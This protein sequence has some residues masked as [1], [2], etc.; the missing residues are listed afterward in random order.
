MW[1]INSLTF[2]LTIIF[3]TVHYTAVLLWFMGFLIKSKSS[4]LSKISH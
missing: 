1:L 3:H 4:G 2:A